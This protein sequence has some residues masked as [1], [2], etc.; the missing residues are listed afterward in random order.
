MSVSDRQSVFVCVFCN[1][2]STCSFL[3]L[4]L[5]TKFYLNDVND[6]RE[7][8]RERDIKVKKPG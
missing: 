4:L 3:F 8:E 2:S 6:E 7:K 5:F 1:H